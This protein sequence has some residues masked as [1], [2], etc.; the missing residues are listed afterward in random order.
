M[1]NQ[2]LPEDLATNLLDRFSS[3]EGY[4]TEANLI[5]T[6]KGLRCLSPHS[7]FN[8][9]VV[10]VVTNSDDRVPSIL[11]SLGINVS[12]LRYGTKTDLTAVTE[13]N[14]DIDFHVMSYDVGVE[15]PDRPIFDAAELMLEQIIMSR[16]SKSPPR[17]KADIKTWRKVY[18]GDEY[19]K[20][21]VGAVNAGW[22]PVLLDN[23]ENSAGIPRL[24]DYSTY[25]L[26]EIFDAHAVIRVHSIQTLVTWLMGGRLNMI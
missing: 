25:T 7:H 24:E 9:L 12:P 4:A 26:D 1:D 3:K 10:G 18:V 22:N 17:A 8:R 23:N 15:K 20:D 16:H 21:V 13:Q 19:A 2:I 6:L 11:S 14:Y 5:P